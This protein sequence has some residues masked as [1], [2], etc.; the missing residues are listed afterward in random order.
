V[1]RSKLPPYQFSVPRNPNVNDNLPLPNCPHHIPSPLAI[2]RPLASGA[3]TALR[4]WTKH[5][6]P[7]ARVASAVVTTPQR[8]R[9]SGEFSP[10]PSFDSPFKGE[11]S[12]PTTKIPSF[13]NYM[14]K[15]SE[16]SNR[17]FQYFMV[18]SM[19]LLAAAGAKATVQGEWK[20]GRGIQRTKLNQLLYIQGH[21]TIKKYS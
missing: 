6:L 2:M 3:G 4:S 11:E 13:K 21:W 18:G 5:S 17:V 14:S 15:S 10:T 1:P 9:V 16:T 8:R 7:S 12:S 19:G 20:I